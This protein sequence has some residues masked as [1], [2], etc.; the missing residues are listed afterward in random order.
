MKLLHIVATPRDESS[1]TM[2]ISRAFIEGLRPKYEDLSVKVIDLFSYD[3]P[4]VAGDNIE[5]KYNLM[6]G[7]KI[8]KASEES[9]KEIESLIANFLRADV[10]LITTPMWNFGIPYALKYY[11]DCIVQPG[12]LF[13]YNELGQPVGMVLGKKMVCVTS[14]GGDYSEQSPMH[15][16]D[17]QEPYLRSIFGFCGIN[18]IDFINAQPLDI[19]LELREHA[20]QK[21]IAEAQEL[22]ANFDWSPS[23]DVAGTV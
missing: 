21:A 18:S 22:A 6:K 19:T 5:V 15:V 13:R 20:L 23:V 3:L 14:R 1:N 17:F 16:F 12:Y 4:S 11:I 8:D 7:I 2:R 10:Y 9:W